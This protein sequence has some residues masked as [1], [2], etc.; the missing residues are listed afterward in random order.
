MVNYYLI[1]I[2][3]NSNQF[4]DNKIGNEGITS[5]SDALKINHSITQLD[6]GGK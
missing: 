2:K 4:K 1:E 3:N 5:L 6:L